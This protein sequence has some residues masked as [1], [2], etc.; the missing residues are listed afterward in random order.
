M[1]D[2]N[3]AILVGVCEKTLPSPLTITLTID[4]VKVGMSRK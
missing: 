1:L 4:D 3:K 2:M